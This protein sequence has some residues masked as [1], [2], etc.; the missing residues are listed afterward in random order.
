MKF[1]EKNSCSI[2][3]TAALLTT[4]KMKSTKMS[5]SRE[6]NKEN[7]IQ[8]ERIHSVIKEWNLVTCRKADQKGGHHFK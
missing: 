7:V 2:T 1:C 3:F 6:M 4:A 8:R 5:T